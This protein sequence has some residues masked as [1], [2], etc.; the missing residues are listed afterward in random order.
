[1]RAYVLIRRPA[2]VQPERHIVAA[3][4]NIIPLLAFVQDM[5]THTDWELTAVGVWIARPKA[6]STPGLPTYTIHSIP[7]FESVKE[8]DRGVREEVAPPPAATQPA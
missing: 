7:W 3:A 1:M 6:T 4:P 5:G 8:M 2:T